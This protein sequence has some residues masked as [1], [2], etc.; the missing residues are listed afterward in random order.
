MFESTSWLPQVWDH[1]LCNPPWFFQY[2]VL[3]YLLSNRVAILRADSP[4][5]CGAL[6]ARPNTL[7][8]TKVLRRAAM[9]LET[10]PADVRLPEEPLQPLAAAEV[11]APFGAPYPPQALQAQRGER[12]RLLGQRTAIVERRRTLAELQV[13]PPSPPRLMGRALVLAVSFTSDAHR[14]CGADTLGEP[15]HSGDSVKALFQNG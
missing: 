10:T 2:V 6:T 1:I 9:A 12:V 3:S 14:H 8:A 15:P 5:A 7:N 11:Y 13:R 4:A